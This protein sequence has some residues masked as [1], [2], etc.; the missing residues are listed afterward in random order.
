M[1]DVETTLDSSVPQQTIDTKHTKVSMCMPRVFS[2]FK[3]PETVE[4]ATLPPNMESEL[5]LHPIQ[6]YL[7]DSIAV[8]EYLHQLPS[9]IPI[10][11][12]SDEDT[13]FLT[14]C[15]YL[16]QGNIDGFEVDVAVFRDTS[17]VIRWNVQD[18]I[19]ERNRMRAFGPKEP[20]LT[21]IEE[22]GGSEEDNAASME[23]GVMAVK[24]SYQASSGDDLPVPDHVSGH[25]DGSDDGLRSYS[26]TFGIYDGHTPTDL[27][28][29]PSE[30]L[31]SATDIADFPSRPGTSQSERFCR[32]PL[33][34]FYDVTLLH[35]VIVQ[36]HLKQIT[37]LDCIPR[38]IS[39]QPW[40]DSSVE[41][42][43]GIQ[44]QPHPDS[45]SWVLEDCQVGTNI[46][47]TRAASGTHK[48]HYWDSRRNKWIRLC[49]RN[50]ERF[51]DD[52][53][54]V[55]VGYSMITSP[56]IGELVLQEC[57]NGGGELFPVTKLDDRFNPVTVDVVPE[58]PSPWSR[59]WDNIVTIPT[60]ASSFLSSLISGAITGLTTI[61]GP[62]PL[63]P[64]GDIWSNININP[65]SGKIIHLRNSWQAQAVPW[66]VAAQPPLKLSGKSQERYRYSLKRHWFG[67]LVR[68][69]QDAREFPPEPRLD[70]LVFENG[71]LVELLLS[72]RE[73]MSDDELK[74]LE[75]KLEEIIWGKD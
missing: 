57:P 73:I 27:S 67:Y 37:E 41:K 71:E 39:A 49:G 19:S 7:R 65:K 75:K 51:L 18:E 26:S 16:P 68:S 43:D 11:D 3:S 8:P 50:K 21:S 58:D 32:Y 20:S 25:L 40:L 6:Q 61:R 72:T 12:L 30:I 13:Q 33:N 53:A 55:Q 56:R 54:R 28:R 52:L 63:Q 4:T 35:K 29:F 5:E 1:E 22:E 17:M 47:L 48:I 60:N 24:D 14:K 45:L 38:I 64:A 74:E 42:V 69:Q 2:K 36:Q 23:S 70:Q 15:D 46:K 31:N 59:P 44:R 66:E 9:H 34:T 10:Q 62:Y